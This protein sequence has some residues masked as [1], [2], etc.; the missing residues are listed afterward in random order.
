MVVDGD[1]VGNV[2]EFRRAFVGRHHQIWVFR[3]AAMCG[4]RCLQA[5]IGQAV[6]G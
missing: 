1:L 4:F 2:G 6:I 5:A 3:I